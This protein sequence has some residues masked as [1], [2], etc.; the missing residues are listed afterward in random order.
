MEASTTQFT[1]S[2]SPD[3]VAD[4]L[5]RLCAALRDPP[6]ARLAAEVPIITAE[7]AGVERPEA[8]LLAARYGLRDRGCS[9][10]EGPGPEGLLP[11]RVG[12]I[13]G[14]SSAAMLS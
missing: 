11:L 5:D 6:V 4:Y 8:P 10:V 12:D 13:A 3:R 2:G 14:G 9:S 1:V 7:L